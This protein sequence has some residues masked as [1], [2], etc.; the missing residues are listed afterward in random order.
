MNYLTWI[1]RESR[2][3]WKP[4]ADS[5]PPDQP[6]VDLAA[7]GMVGAGDPILASY[8][9]HLRLDAPPGTGWRDN[10]DL[11]HGHA[12]LRQ[13]LARLY[14]LPSPDHALPT[15]GGSQALFLALSALRHHD[16]TPTVTLAP[17]EYGPL[18]EI[19]RSLG[20]RLVNLAA[21]P[22]PRVAPTPCLH[23]LSNPHNPTGTFLSPAGIS[24]LL[25]SLPPDSQ[26]LV[27]ESFLSPA[28]AHLSSATL[29]DP[30]IITIGGL[31]KPLG[32]GS[33]RT[34]WILAHGPTLDLLRDTWVQGFNIGSPLTESL[35]AAILRD[36]N[37]HHAPLAARA[38]SN[39]R[40]LT[41]HLA[42]LESRGLIT[43][44]RPSRGCITFPRILPLARSPDPRAAA[45]QFYNHL[46]DHHRLA[47]VPGAWFTPAGSAEHAAHVRLSFGASSE[48][49]NDGLARLARAII[50]LA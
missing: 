9:D 36:V 27:D 47:V 13:E 3:R 30:R 17:P 37:L 8:P 45:V 48:T 34:G 15:A 31:T 5:A 28:D 23:L 21:P 10:A 1:K 19:P 41:D 42:P 26:L 14:S 4:L 18:F 32:L 46:L 40:T 16:P 22:E 29:A 49:L 24:H 7:S 39:L 25:S 44:P 50:E 11:L 20:F 38:Q 43:W 6:L 2:Q 12:G 35:A 33:L